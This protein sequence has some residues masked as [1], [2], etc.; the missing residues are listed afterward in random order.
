V[1]VVTQAAEGNPHV[2]L[3]WSGERDPDFDKARGEMVERDLASRDVKDGRVLDAF[4][5]VPRERFVWQ[6]HLQEAYADHPLRIGE[7]QTISQP[8]MV[9]LMTQCLKPAEAEKILEIGTGSGYQTAILAELAREVRTVERIESLSASARER[10]A[11]LGYDNIRFRVGDGTLG[12]PEEAPFDGI[13]VTAGAPEVPASLKA[14]L[15][16][17]GRLVIPVGDRHGQD[18][19]VVTRAGDEFETRSGCPCVFVKLIGEEGWPEG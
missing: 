2:K 16:E 14:Q 15:A 4:R 18:L 17:G 1:E 5:R 3:P 8:Y 7:G 11:A 10:L 19:L 12:W 13:I 9:A 6:A